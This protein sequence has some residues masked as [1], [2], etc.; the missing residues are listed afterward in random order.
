MS[1]LFLLVIS[2]AINAFVGL[3]VYIKNPKSRL[4]QLLVI[5]VISMS[6]WVVANYLADKSSSFTLFWNRAAFVGPIFMALSAF[7]FARFMTGLK[8]LS[9]SQWLLV[10]GSAIA[11][12]V[13]LSPY[14]VT[15]V[16]PR[17]AA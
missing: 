15:G 9:P 10:L 14:A 8:R 12:V 3:F 17:V 1:E 13:S 2:L 16:T 4:N 7:L 5:L 11:G 6:E